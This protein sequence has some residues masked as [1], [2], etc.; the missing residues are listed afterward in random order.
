[1]GKDKDDRFNT[2]IPCLIER[3]RKTLQLFKIHPA[4]QPWPRNWPSMEYFRY[5]IE[6]VESAY[7]AFEEMSIPDRTTM[8]TL[9][10]ARRE[11]KDSLA[12]LGKCIE[13]T[14]RSISEDRAVSVPVGNTPRSE[15]QR[16]NRRPPTE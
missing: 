8:H 16:K 12:Y 9:T 11:L 4:F 10:S 3:V 13:P 2:S 14:V 5:K 6:A 7:Q 1:M 15:R